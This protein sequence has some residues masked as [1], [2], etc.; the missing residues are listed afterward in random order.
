MWLKVRF[1]IH[2][3]DLLPFFWYAAESDS[4]PKSWPLGDSTTSELNRCEVAERAVRSNRVVVLAPLF[5]D[6]LGVRQGDE[7]VL[8][9]PL[10]AKPAVE[11]FDES[12]LRWL[13]RFDESKLDAVVSENTNGA[14]S[15]N[16]RG[17][18]EILRDQPTRHWVCDRRS[19]ADLSSRSSVPSS[20]RARTPMRL[21]GGNNGASP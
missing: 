5:D 3:D 15:S 2:S 20:L 13:T 16:P 7:P 11:A 8:I 14:E 18:L 1:K 6:A 19:R 10:I 21:R 4:F 12:V 9:E 17:V